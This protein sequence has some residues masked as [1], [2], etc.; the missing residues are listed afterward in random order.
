MKCRTF[1]WDPLDIQSLYLRINC[2]FGFRLELEDQKKKE[3]S[4]LYPL[5]GYSDVTL[6]CLIS[7]CHCKPD[8]IRH[9]LQAGFPEHLLLHTLLGKNA[10]HF[11]INYDDSESV[12][13]LLEDK[14]RKKILMESLITINE[15][16]KT[17]KEY[18]EL[19][20]YS[21]TDQFR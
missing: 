20:G 5:L 1:M 4:G 21:N 3:L 14:A 19:C 7:Y 6:L 2:P 12:H 9:L 16:S 8:V 13:V 15:Q 10:L 17:V 18:A 11:A